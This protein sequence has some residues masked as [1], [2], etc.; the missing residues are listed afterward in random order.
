MSDL[1]VTLHEALKEYNE[2]YLA[3]DLVLFEAAMQHVCRICRIIT[4]PSGHALLVG[5]GGSGKQSLARLSAHICNYSTT[6]IAISSNYG[7]NELKADLQV[8][9][10]KAG[11][12]DEGVLFLFTEGQIADER[13]LIYLNDLL[14]SG[15][16][17]DLFPSEEKDRIVNNVRPAAK[18]AGYADT[19]ESLWSFFIGRIR[20]NLHVALCFSPVGDTL[21]S[22][23][24]KFPGLI[25]STVI[26]W[27]QPWPAEA[28]HSVAHRFLDEIPVDDPEVKTSIISFMPFS[29]YAV[30]KAAEDYLAYERR[31]AY[32][33]PKS[34]LELIKLYK[35]MLYKNLAAVEEK[36]GRLSEGLTK[37]RDTQEKVS[38]LE[39]TL[40]EKTVEVEEK[41]VSADAFAEEVGKE[42]VKVA[43]ESEKATIEAAKCAE[44]QKDVSVQ[45][46][47]CEEGA[48]RNVLQLLLRTQLKPPHS[49][50]RALD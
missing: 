40:K 21:R 6:Q 28:L 10:N 50:L 16:I 29:F 45:Q 37:L 11:V 44:I 13:F 3:M 41:K 35:S 4:N 1:S 30:N 23:S 8:M 39:E 2:T 24:R 5:V 15:D 9:F 7:V 43:A 12:K 19:K 20:K 49:A 18:S 14:S 25:N 47:S 31:Y 46:T 38:A 34:F 33:T 26:D 17:A 22:M 36:K 27:F 42:K 32:S 48:V